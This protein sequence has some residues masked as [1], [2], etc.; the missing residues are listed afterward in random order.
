MV[1]KL[2]R[3]GVLKTSFLL[4]I[5]GFV[6]GLIIGII[7]ALFSSLLFSGVPIPEGI[8]SLATGFMAILIFP[9]LYGII[10]LVGGFIF[11]PIF[12]LILKLIKGIDLEIVEEEVVVQQ[13]PSP[14]A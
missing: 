3:V 11:T 5:Y 6:I 2:K 1:I 8:F 12:N 7:T 14:A 10:G 13:K 4:G 9:I